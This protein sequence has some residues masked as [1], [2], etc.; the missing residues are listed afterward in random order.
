MCVREWEIDDEK[1]NEPTNDGSN[2]RTNEKGATT[3]GTR[4]ATEGKGY[5]NAERGKN[6]FFLL[7]LRRSSGYLESMFLPMRFALRPLMRA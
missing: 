5:G 3:S 2:E 1:Q 4:P 6:C 7:H